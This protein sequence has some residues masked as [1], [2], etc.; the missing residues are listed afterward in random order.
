ME[1]QARTGAR[2]LAVGMEEE[3]AW[4]VKELQPDFSV[5]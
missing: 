3:S 5:R 2:N 4:M 1:R